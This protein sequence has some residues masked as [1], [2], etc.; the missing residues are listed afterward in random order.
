MIDDFLYKDAISR[1]FNL[2]RLR[3]EM[4]FENEND[5]GDVE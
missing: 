2:P 4:W 5:D 3:W 1:V